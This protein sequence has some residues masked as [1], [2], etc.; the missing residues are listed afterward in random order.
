L[1]LNQQ[2][3]GNWKTNR[4]VFNFFLK[5]LQFVDRSKNIDIEKNGDISSPVFNTNPNNE[6]IV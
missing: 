3:T 6:F 5:G 1:D 4:N 2:I